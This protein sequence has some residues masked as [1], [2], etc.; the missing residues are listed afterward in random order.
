MA[1][2][3]EGPPKGEGVLGSARFPVMADY[4]VRY[5]DPRQADAIMKVQQELD[6]TKIVLVSGMERGANASAMVPHTIDKL[7][8]FPTSLFHLCPASPQH[9]TIE[10]V[11]AR[12]EH[13]DSL[14]ERSE[15]LQASSK[16]F[17]KSAKKQNSCCVVM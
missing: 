9:K 1:G 5:Q 15:T 7:T 8:S 17:Y 14:V 6:E 2:S 13:L 3:V 11:L 12:G 16:M 10:S 4:V